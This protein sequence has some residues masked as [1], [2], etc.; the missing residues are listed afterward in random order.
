MPQKHYHWK[1]YFKHKLSKPPPL[2]TVSVGLNGEMNPSILSGLQREPNKDCFLYQLC[3]AG[4]ACRNKT[5]KR[6]K[7]KY[8]SSVNIVKP[9]CNVNWGC[10]KR[11][12]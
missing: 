11:G 4:V 9:G 3:R 7:N 5:E 2:V 12:D 1:K 6:N 8:S 10:L